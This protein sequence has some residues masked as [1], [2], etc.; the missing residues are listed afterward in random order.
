LAE[1]ADLHRTYISG[2]EGGTRN[3]TLKSIDKLARALGVSTAVLLSPA[4]KP[5]LQ[6]GD[7]R[8]EPPVGKFVD[9]LLVEDDQA[10]VELTLHAFQKARITNPIHIVNDGAEALD[11]LF[12]RGRYANRKMEN[13]PQ[14]VLL[15]LNLPKV[16]GLEVLRRIK[17]DGSTRTIPVIV[18][19]VSQR[20]RDIVECR[21]LG[22][23]TYIVKPV[24]FVNF[25]EVTPQLSLRWG[26]LEPAVATQL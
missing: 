13:R 16:G 26:L 25:S 12:C 14:L 1:R 10:D 7:L 2:I 17:S 21:R 20:D 24:D 15:D 11:F 5:A 19:T 8:S 3:V 6:P 23:E 18:L 22:A 4:S 9:I